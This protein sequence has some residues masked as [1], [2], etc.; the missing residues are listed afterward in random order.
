MDI[1]PRL[2]STTAAQSQPQSQAPSQPPPPSSQ[3]QS[4]PRPK[5]SD[6]QPYYYPDPPTSIPRTAPAP[7]PG[8]GTGT[9]TQYYSPQQVYASSSLG[10]DPNDPLELKRPRACEA[11]RQL[12]VR[13]EPDSS[14]PSGSCKRCAKTGRNCVVTAPTRKRQ[15]KTDTRVAELERKIDALTAS[16]QAQGDPV[17]NK[18]GPV[19]TS[20]EDPGRRWLGA[21]DQNQDQGRANGSLAGRKR[22]S[23]GE[24]KESSTAVDGPESEPTPVWCQQ[25]L[26]ERMEPDVI[27]RGL[28]DVEAATAAFDRYVNDMAPLVPFI[29]FPAGTKM[30]DI[31]RAKPILLHAIIAAAIGP[32]QPSSQLALTHEFYKVVADRVVVRGEKS[33]ELVQAINVNWIWYLPP[34]HFEE[35]KFYQ[36]VH[37]AVVM[38]MDIGMNRRAI[39][40]RKPFNLI[41][42]LVGKRP[43]SLDPD[44]PETRR[45]WL[46]CYFGSVQ[47]VSTSGSCSTRLIV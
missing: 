11:C 42:D 15:K 18:P 7:G 2:C 38:G 10:P 30:E 19:A 27:D 34:D 6:S 37:M 47:Y 43:S 26:P 17:P 25:P 33:L 16:L 36:V 1:D 9:S 20:E 22:V 32:I 45:A 39:A 21:Q 23:T 5:R 46:A 14:H 24:V 35:L 3:S 44:S 40:N 41:R 8:S 13:C 31:R 4:Q 28:V 12:K 29:V